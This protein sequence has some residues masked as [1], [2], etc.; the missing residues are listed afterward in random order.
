AIRMPVLLLGALT[1]VLFVL[2]VQSVHGRRAAIVGGLLLTSDTS[3]LLTTCFDWGPV[4]LQHLFLVAGMLL[5][6]RSRFFLG[7][8]LFGLGIW[9]KALFI[10]MLVGLAVATVCVFRRELWQR[11]TPRNVS[12]A[13]A[14]F[15]LGALPLIVYNVAS[16]GATFRANSSFAFDDLRLKVRVLQTT[17][18]GSALFGYIVNVPETGSPRAA[19]TVLERASFALHDALGD[20]RQN[21][22]Q[23]AFFVGLLLSL[24]KRGRVPLFCLIVL[25]V[26]WLQM[27]ITKGAGIA[28]HHA[29][30]LWPVPHMFLAVTF[31]EASLHWKKIGAWLLAAGVLILAAGNVLVTNQY[32]YQ[33]ARYGGAGSWTDAIYP[34]SQVAG[35]LPAERIVI[36]DW[37]IFSPL[38]WLHSGKLP[39][40]LAGDRFLSPGTSDLQKTWDRGL[41][42]RGLWLGHTPGYEQFRGSTER[43]V[44]RATAAGFRK[45]LI[46]VVADR[47]GRAIFEV[48]RFVPN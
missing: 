23:A 28:A 35:R 29:V 42:E 45:D 32:L 24:W 19:E 47:N 41:L 44:A 18:N 16:G 22:L 25:A 3:F 7:F 14:G 37:G 1:V 40:V 10:W 8:V 39:L 11:F 31:A 17:W 9:D 34:L 13:A 2:L 20:H 15:C 43:I 21:W 30:L 5:I 27:A 33:L 6:L 48:F 46:Q 38:Q 4:T 12:L 36:D 26:A